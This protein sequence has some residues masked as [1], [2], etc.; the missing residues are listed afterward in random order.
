MGATIFF[1]KY[2]QGGCEKALIEGYSVGVKGQIRPATDEI[3]TPHAVCEVKVD[4]KVIGYNINKLHL[5]QSSDWDKHFKYVNEYPGY[6]IVGFPFSAGFPRMYAGVK[7]SIILVNGEILEA[8]VDDSRE[9]MSEGL[10]WKTREGNKSSSAV[11]AWK[12]VWQ[13]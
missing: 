13:P 2:S 8:M 5:Q 4:E 10:E 9:F 7:Y 3:K 1:E 6:R 11:A 12:E